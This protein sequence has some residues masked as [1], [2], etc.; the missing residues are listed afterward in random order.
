MT[1]S[2]QISERLRR[3]VVAVTAAPETETVGQTVLRLLKARPELGG[4]DWVLDIRNPHEKAPLEELEQIAAAFNQRTTT[5]A[6]TVFVSTDPATYDR[7]ALLG[8]RF[9][10]RCHLVAR[11][12]AEVERLLP[13]AMSF[14]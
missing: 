10:R 14:I 7:C 8:A 4:W 3:V 12:M 5:M 6:Y 11:D 13:Q 9:Q 2:T 1:T